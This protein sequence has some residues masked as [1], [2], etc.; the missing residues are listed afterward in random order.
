MQHLISLAFLLI[1]F[2]VGVPDAIAGGGKLFTISIF[3]LIGL[4]PIEA[5]AT[6]QVV[7]LIQEIV[8]PFAFDKED[9]INWKQALIFAPA[10]VIGSFLGANTAVRMDPQL[11]S[12]VAGG[13]MI[14][15]LFFIP[16]IKKEE[17]SFNHFLDKIINKFKSNQPIITHSLKQTSFLM[18][19]TLII[20]FYNGFYGAGV[21]ILM[22][23][24]FYFIGNAEFIAS[25]ATTKA[26]NVFMSAVASF[27]FLSKA[28]I[29]QWSYA[30]PMML[31]T[32]IGCFVGVK[33]GKNLGYKYIRIIMYLI[34]ASSAVKFI[35]F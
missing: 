1:G 30:F 20:G 22:V 29:I 10:A 11:L 21:G 25:N 6:M 19:F 9:L 34:V 4:P 17:F 24:G 27:V 13:I 23:L 7:T 8:T 31:G 16:Q 15:M 14:L 32:I 2:L 12:K 35:F 18:L 28:D 5:I 33:W 26:I 3:S